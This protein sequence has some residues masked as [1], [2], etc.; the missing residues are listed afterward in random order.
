M[1][2][3]IRKLAAASALLLAAAGT[4]AATVTL[5]G[6]LVAHNDIVRI[7]FMLPAAADVKIWTDSWLSGLNFDPTA[8]VWAQT[9]NDHTLVAAV[10]DDDTVGPGQGYYDSGIL[11]PALA[12]GRYLVTLATAINGPIGALLSQG[13]AYDSEAPIALALW[14][15]PTYD[16]NLNDQKGSAWRINFTGVPQAALAVP[17]PGSVLLVALALGLMA[18]SS[19]R[20]PS[21]RRPGQ[22]ALA[23]PRQTQ[24]HHQEEHDDPV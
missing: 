8:A 7:D 23:K 12:A 3:H 11:L 19:R 20:P 16:P 9:G 17:A 14:N 1:H 13:F 10:D 4:Q 6:N 21:H 15:Q 22:A 2:T 18:A 5:S 24:L